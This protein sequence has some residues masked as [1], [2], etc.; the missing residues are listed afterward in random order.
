MVAEIH[1]GCRVTIQATKKRAH[2]RGGDAASAG[3]G[4]GVDE[5]LKAQA[6]VIDI[7]GRNALPF[8]GFEKRLHGIGQG[9][10]VSLLA[11]EFQRVIDRLMDAPSKGGKLGI[12][13]CARPF[14]HPL[15]P[16][17][18]GKGLCFLPCG[19]ESPLTFSIDSGIH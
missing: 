7:A 11:K 2:R 5:P 19:E 9:H 17:A 10:R 14:V 12:E 6:Q 1:L 13:D 16:L 4:M 15:H 8:L 18:I 3:L